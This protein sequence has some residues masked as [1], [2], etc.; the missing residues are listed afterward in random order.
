MA[1]SSRAHTGPIVIMRVKGPQRNS[2]A[3]GLLWERCGRPAFNDWREGNRQAQVEAV[4]RTG[5]AGIL[6]IPELGGQL[7]RHR[8]SG[9]GITDFH[10]VQRDNV[11]RP[12]QADVC[13]C[14]RRWSKLPNP[15]Y[16]QSLF[17]ESS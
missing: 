1:K 16:F 2:S 9:S 6:P 10:S 8:P 5:E 12:E 17:S 4:F 7:F 13:P 11:P 15:I 14:A 3:S